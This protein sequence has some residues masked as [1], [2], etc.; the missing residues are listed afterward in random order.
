[1]RKRFVLILFGLL[2][3]PQL[4]HAQGLDPARLV[5]PLTSDR[6][7]NQEWPTFNGDYTGRRYSA[8]KQI[9]DGKRWQAVPGLGIPGA[10]QRPA[11][12]AS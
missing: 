2:L 3:A 11:V 10:R 4:F 6:P 12:H 5:T 8:L 1:M 9:N 7:P